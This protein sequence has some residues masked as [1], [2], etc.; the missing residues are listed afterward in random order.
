MAATFTWMVDHGTASGS[1]AVGSSSATASAVNWLND[2]SESTNSSFP[3][4]AGSN[5]YE[6]FNYGKFSGTFTTISAGLWAHTSTSFG[7]GLTLRATYRAPTPHPR[8]LQIR[9]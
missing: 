9:A 8:L 2:D 1:P 3:I 7:T 4:T 5:S 6:K